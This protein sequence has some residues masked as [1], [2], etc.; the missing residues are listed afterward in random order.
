M[1]CLILV[2]IA[3]SIRDIKNLVSGKKKK[4]LVVYVI[5]MLLVSA[6]AIYY[7]SNPE[8]GSFSEILLSLIGKEGGL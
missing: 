3:V 5:I 8:S 1:V 7:Y 6:F 4:D 2:I